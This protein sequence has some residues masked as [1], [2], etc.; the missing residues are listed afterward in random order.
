MLVPTEPSKTTVIFGV[1]GN[2]I[3]HLF[4][5]VVACSSFISSPKMDLIETSFKSLYAL[6]F[7]ESV[8]SQVAAPFEFTFVGK[9]FLH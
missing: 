7:D 9:C 1:S 3:S 6:M 5:Y 4:K 2:G 8:I